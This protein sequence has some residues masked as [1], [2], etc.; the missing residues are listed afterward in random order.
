MISKR[1]LWP[2]LV[3]LLTVGGLLASCAPAA[4]PTPTKA[5]A[6]PPAATKAPAAAPAPTKAPAAAPAATKAPA[7]AP[8]TPKPAAP[9]ATPKPA[10]E[11]PQSGGILTRSSFGDPA[12]M[13]LHQENSISASG[14]YSPAYNGLIKFDPINIGKIVPDLAEKWDVS[15]D[16][17]I[18]TFHLRKGVKFH[19]GKEFTSEDAVFSL[20]RMSHSKDF[21]TVAPR[22]GMLIGAI[23]TAEAT[24]PYTVK[25]TLSNPQ[26]S[27]LF[28]AANDWIKMMPK[29][30][31]LANQG[32]MKHVVNGTGPF[33]LKQFARGVVVHL[34][35]NPDYFVKGRPYLDE[36]K[37]YPIPDDTTRFVALR[38]GKVLCTTLASRAIAPEQ[39]E[40]VKQNMADKIIIGTHKSNSQWNIEFNH[41]KAPWS[42]LRVRKAVHLAVSRQNMH[43]VLKGYADDGDV[44]YADGPFGIPL[45]DLLQKP[46]WREPKDQDIAE[47]KKLMAEAGLAQGIKTSLLTRDGSN[48]ADVA[49]SV[50]R[51]LAQIGID[52]TIDQRTQAQ[53]NDMYQKGTYEFTVYLWAHSEDDPGTIYRGIYL[54]EKSRIQSGF[55]DKQIDEWFLQQET[56]VD[57]TKR[58]EIVR[59]MADKIVA[60]VA[61]VNLVWQGYI[62][63]YWKQVRNFTQGPGPYYNNTMEQVWLAK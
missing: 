23:K 54:C 57:E 7:A 43:K 30:T 52:A 26:A 42:D 36:Y 41:A 10:G 19:D 16:G 17:T 21:G 46:G 14:P 50:Q 48:F 63:A 15:S 49:Q 3:S 18:Y 1:R 62:Y 6:A 9:A 11:Q 8:A 29:H 24:D 27:F 45:K 40:W 32:H 22:G 34:V 59:K 38:T 55:C 25:V 28:F 37:V 44:H 33:K 35:K 58:R 13:D 12:T 20:M 2:I 53:V 61:S 56:T 31:I 60:D 39:A 51:D 4:A 47:A 5:P